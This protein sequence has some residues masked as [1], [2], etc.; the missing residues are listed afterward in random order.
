VEGQSTPLLLALGRRLQAA[1]GDAPGFLRRVQREHPADFWA[2]LTLGNALKYQGPGEAIGYYRVALAIRPGVAVGYYNLGEVLRYQNWL[3]EAIDYYQQALR[4]DPGNV[5]AHVNCGSVLAE[6]DRPDE[7]L[8]HFRQAVRLDPANVS[9]Q[10]NLGVA[11]KD[12][13]RLDEALDHLQQAITIDPKN[14]SAQNGLRGVLMRQGRGEEVQAAWR[15]AL[16]ANP[17]EHDAWFGYAELCLF[18]GQEE[19]YRSNCRALLE[20]FGAN[21][22]PF[23]AERVGRACLLRPGSKDELAQAAALIDRALAPGPP[24]NDRFR[25][26]FLFAKALAEYRQGRL[27]SAIA[28]TQGDAPR[29]IRPAARLVRAMAQYRHGQKE[30]ARRTLAG[31]V[32]AFDWSADQADNH[33]A[34]ICHILR[35][36]AEAMIL[37]N[38]PAFLE[39]NYQPRDN[40]ERVALLGVCQ[41]QGLHRAAVR[42]YADAFAAD[43]KLADDLEAGSRCRAARFAALAAAGR[44]KDARKLDDQ[45]RARLRRQ[46]LD[47]LRGDLAACSRATDRALVQKTLLHWQQDADFA[48]VRDE[49]ALARLPRAERE[50]WR[51]LWSDVADLL[52]RTGGLK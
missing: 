46:A 36:E 13:G 28:L 20:R 52:Q 24:E 43:P 2:N 47:W 39:G 45:E 18:L 32:L 17:P 9:A 6:K 21:W 40:D 25:P 49:E 16:E 38:L 15:K 37:P 1:G 31:A 29:E 51:Q 23:L 22:D 42:L 19:E 41:F 50:A 30:E 48:G 14:A 34:W 7:A 4:V 8:D 3:D 10:V 35:R 33:D 26:F 27:D 11:L 44:G 12:K 5:W